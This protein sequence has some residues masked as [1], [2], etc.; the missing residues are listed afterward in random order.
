[1][2]IPLLAIAMSLTLDSFKAAPRAMAA[3]TLRQAMTECQDLQDRGLSGLSP[4]VSGGLAAQEQLSESYLA[5][6]LA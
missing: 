6:K 1:M 2:L 4:L 5:T 3:E